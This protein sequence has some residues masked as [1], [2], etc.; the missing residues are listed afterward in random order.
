MSKGI[1]ITGTDT[2]VGK[3]VV[4]GLLARYLLESGVSVITQKWV[5]TGYADFASSDIGQ[6]LSMMR[7]EKYFAGSY[8]KH[9]LPYTFKMPSSAHLA[10]RLEKRSI[11]QSKII[12]SFRFLAE[13]FDCVLVEG[14]GGALVPLSSKGLIIDIAK[15]L[16]LPVLIVAQNKLG[17]IN[18]TLLTIEALKKRKFKIL[19]IVFNDSKTDDALIRKDNPKIIKALSK[20]NVF[21]VLP[22]IRK[23]DEL[24]RA[25]LP[26]G[27][28][29]RREVLR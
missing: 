23:Q 2:G 25:F 22:R 3:T 27:E 6:H 7:G 1:F 19:G 28:K 10:S 17:A 9:L 29:I 18:H 12:K 5:Q 24:Y 20:V 21:G 14:A 26:L 15:K 11:D 8:Q 16:D 4:T 13:R